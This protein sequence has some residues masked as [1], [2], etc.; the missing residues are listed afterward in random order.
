[1]FKFRTMK[2]C[3][4]TEF[5]NPCKIYSF[6]SEIEIKKN[7]LRNENVIPVFV[8]PNLI[9]F[10]TKVRFTDL[11]AVV[12]GYLLTKLEYTSK[13]LVVAMSSDARP[14]SAMSAA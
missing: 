8:S 5:E 10:M 9:I 2:I 6:A 14:M 1:M 4:S 3:F 7:L 12:Y 11:L 13:Y